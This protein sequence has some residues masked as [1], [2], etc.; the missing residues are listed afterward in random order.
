LPLPPNHFLIKSRWTLKLKPG[1]KTRPPTYKARFVAKGFSQQ[2][3]GID[4]NETEIYAPVVK[5]DFLRILLSIA[6][7]LD[8]KLVQLDVTTAFLYG[9]FDEE[10]NVQQPES[11]ILSGKEKLVCRFLKSL[12]GLKQAHRKWNEKFYR[13]LVLFGLTR[14][15]TDP[16]IYYCV[17][18]NS[19]DLVL[20]KLW[21]DDFHIA[22][23]SKA[24]AL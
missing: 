22:S 3:A 10:L 1:S 11:F 19:N 2:V 14:S 20:I 9:D 8:L 4:Y 15:T 5:H 17:Y 6:T 23:K 13:F 24:K 12:Y 16:C 18:D 21:V 7:T